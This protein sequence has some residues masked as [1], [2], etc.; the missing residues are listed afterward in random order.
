MDASS[1]PPAPVPVEPNPAESP[2]PHREGRPGWPLSEAALAARRANL[3]K[4]RAADKDLIYRPTERRRAASRA[5]LQKAIAGRRSP[6]G[7]ARARLNALQ[8]G[9]TVKPRPD[10]LTSLGEAPEDFARH[11]QLVQRVFPPETELEED[12]V[13]RLA[14]ISWRRIR[15]L[16]GRA[17]LESLLW[18]RWADRMGKPR[19]LSLE[20]IT[21]RVTAI[22]RRLERAHRVEDESYNLEGRID[23]ILV[24]LIRGRAREEGVGD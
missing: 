1:V 5:N 22:G 6:Q 11:R 2:P 17:R 21:E 4:A 10:I 24:A 8:H 13:E 16:R 12:L 19:R 15:L 18:R 23:R 3:A 20:E 14:R 7:N 9:L